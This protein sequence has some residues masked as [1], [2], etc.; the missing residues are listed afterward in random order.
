MSESTEP[1][2][3]ACCGRDLYGDASVET[4]IG[5]ECR[6]KYAVGEFAFGAKAREA[7]AIV[8]TLAH[9]NIGIRKAAPAFERLAELGFVVLAA[10]IAKRFH[11]TLAPK[12]SDAE[13][14]EL[15]KQYAKLRH[16]FC[17]DNDFTPRD[18][19]AHVGSLSPRSPVEFVKYAQE[20]TCMCKRCSGSGQYVRYSGSQVASMNEC[21][22]CEGKGHQTLEDARRNRA[23]DEHHRARRAS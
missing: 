7:K 2:A 17:Y 4:G 5:P 13:V 15:R 8:R 6:K 19:D 21:Y 1:T 11:A 23:Y 10:R 14:A 20:V 22:R 9:K 18:F 3:C 12:L 16:D